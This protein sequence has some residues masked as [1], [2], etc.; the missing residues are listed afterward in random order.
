[1]QDPTRS[2]LDTPTARATSRRLLYACAALALGAVLVSVPCQAAEA[3]P[4]PSIAPQQLYSLVQ[5][6]KAP[7]ILDVRSPKEFASGHIQG[8]INIPHTEVQKRLPE[9]EKYR[10]QEIVVHCEGGGRAAKAEKI[11]RQNGFTDVVDLQGSMQGWKAKS[12]PTVR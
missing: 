6:K 3:K 10:N 1:M 9:L 11:L 8:A 12:L 7:V 2:K 4:T 5:A